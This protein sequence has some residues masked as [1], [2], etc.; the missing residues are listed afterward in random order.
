MK[1]QIVTIGVYG[2]DKD[3]FFQALL[4]ATNLNVRILIEE[5]G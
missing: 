2:F 5:H 4:H 1:P 3:S